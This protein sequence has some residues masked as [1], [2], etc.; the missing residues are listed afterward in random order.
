M[1]TL[2]KPETLICSTCKANDTTRRLGEGERKG[3]SPVENEKGINK[4]KRNIEADGGFKLQ[5][6]QQT[7]SALEGA[8][9]EW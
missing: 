4:E 5:G 1:R 9:R 7:G 3:R 2:C 6:C 8:H